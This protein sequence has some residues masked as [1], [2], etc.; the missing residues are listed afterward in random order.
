MEVDTDWTQPIKD[1]ILHEK[2]PDD[3]KQARKICTKSAKY[4]LIDDNLYRTMG[5]W[6]LLK[7]VSPADGQYVLREIHEGI[8]GS[9]IETKALV[10]K[11][12][13]YG[14]YWPTIKEDS[15]YLVETYTKCQVHANEHHI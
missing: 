2:L 5:N 3:D 9:P 10:N 1:F 7:C 11:A 13:R 12:L 15:I 6:P 4:V 14:Y 8:C